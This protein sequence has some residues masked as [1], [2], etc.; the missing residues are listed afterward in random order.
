MEI[1]RAKLTGFQNLKRISHIAVSI[2]R[3]ESITSSRKLALAL[4][5]YDNSS[6]FVIGPNR[7]DRMLK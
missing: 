6:G 4:S 1:E 5:F 7:Q 2:P 3:M